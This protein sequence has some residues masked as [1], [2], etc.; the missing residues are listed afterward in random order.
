VVGD[1][2]I[3]NPP[4]VA[5]PATV[6]GLGE[7]HILNRTE[8]IVNWPAM[9]AH[10]LARTLRTAYRTLAPDHATRGNTVY[11][12][13]HLRFGGPEFRNDDFFLESARFE[14]CRL[15]DSCGLT[16]ASIVLDVGCGV[17]RLPIGILEQVGEIRH[18]QGVDVDARS[19][20]WCK[21]HIQNVHADFQFQ[22]LDVY[23]L[24]YN[25]AGAPLNCSFRL[26]FGDGGFDI[27]Y[28]YSVFSH[29]TAHDIR[30]YLRECRR[31]LATKGRVFLTAFVEEGVP[32]E[33]EN[34]LN[35]RMKWKAPLHCVR[36]NKSFFSRL[37]LEAGF[38]ISVFNYAKE[39]DGQ[40]GIYLAP[41]LS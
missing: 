18:Y 6:A 24:R 30:I 2:Q 7:C 28:L 29:M 3:K 35:Y 33:V 34:P 26:P 14:A 16:Q 5:R 39:T 13:K 38:E 36:F 15:A 21:E 19:V 10:P 27:V 41:T 22:L 1:E 37:V 20:H 40:S 12:A 11:P 9:R 4:A 25:P 31:L 23:N 8:E 17:G 32:D